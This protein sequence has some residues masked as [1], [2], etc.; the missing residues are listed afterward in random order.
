MTDDA[1]PRASI[2]KYTLR[3]LGVDLLEILE[4]RQLS[5]AIRGKGRHSFFMTGISMKALSGLSSCSYFLFIYVF[6]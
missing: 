6:S 5:V 1:R 4:R 3:T 2:V